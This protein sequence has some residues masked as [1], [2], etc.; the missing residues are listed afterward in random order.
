MVYTGHTGDD[1]LLA[2]VGSVVVSLSIINFI[3]HGILNIILSPVGYS[4]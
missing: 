1:L 2:V 3:V 4:L